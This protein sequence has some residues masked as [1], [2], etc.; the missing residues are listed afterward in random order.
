MTYNSQVFNVLKTVKENLSGNYTTSQLLQ[1]LDIMLFSAIDEVIDSGQWLDTCVGQILTWYANSRRRKLSSC[2]KEETLKLLYLFLVVDNEEKKLL[3]RR[4]ELDRSIWIFLIQIFLNHS[5]AAYREIR[6]SDYG[7]YV[8]LC[9][10]IRNKL[11][12]NNTTDFYSVH[13]NVDMWLR[14]A[15]QFR[16]WM[17]EKYMRHVTNQANSYYRKSSAQ[18]SLDE[19]LQNF[20]AAVYKAIDKCSSN[21]GTLTTVVNNEIRGVFTSKRHQ[22]DYGIAYD[23]PNNFKQ[24]IAATNTTNFSSS[25][26]SD[27]ALS[28][29]VDGPDALI[30]RLSEIHNFRRVMKKYDKTGVARLSLGVGEILSKK[31]IRKL[32]KS[33]IK[34][35]RKS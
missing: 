3:I 17:A 23:I 16:N 24:Q 20:M 19:I 27:D 2:R 8:M 34:R 26:D 30:E 25:L 33:F 32:N 28:L 31:E 35:S 21:M 4:M 13:R 7:K 5:K 12:G 1:T 14:E 9:E 11:R 29:S 18:L 10:D 15:L 22:I 6:A